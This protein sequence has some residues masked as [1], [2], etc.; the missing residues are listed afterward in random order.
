[1]SQ[2]TIKLSIILVNWNVQDLLATC[3]ASID[4]N[5]TLSAL[6]KVETIVVDNA[7]TDGSVKM[8]KEEYPW[9]K[10]IANHE[11]SGFASANNQ[12]IT[13]A[14]GNYIL[15]LNPD[16]YLHDHALATLIDYLDQNPTVGAVGPLLENP[17]GSLQHSC[18][19]TP[20]L[21]REAYRLVR[22]NRNV[23]SGAYPMQ[24]WSTTTPRPVDVIQGACLL[25]RRQV[26]E[27]V[28]LLDEAYFMYTEEVDLC[29]RISRAG[30]QLVWVPQARVTHYGGQ[31]TRQ[32]ATKMFLHLY[33][34]KIIYFR[35]HHGAMTARLYKLILMI[36]SVIRI[37]AALPAAM[38][39]P[40]QRQQYTRIAANY[41]QLL[42]TLPAI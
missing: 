39:A 19:P 21:L 35:K 15:L 33:A 31:S 32:V 7:S 16:T 36:A 26:L 6:P 34:S 8:L 11:N 30:W 40:T 12:G 13:Q 41:R 17:D 24:E 25:L 37:A 10:L 3:L 2:N 23:G 14:S 18:Y 22:P 4:R 27:Q 38:L 9:V 29:T 20:S 1:M 5:V 28:G 42:A